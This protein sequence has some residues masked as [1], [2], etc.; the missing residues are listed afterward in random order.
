MLALNAKNEYR[1]SMC[2]HVC[3]RNGPQDI[4]V[5]IVNCHF[6]PADLDVAA[7]SLVCQ[8]VAYVD[9]LE[10]VLLIDCEVRCK[11]FLVTSQ[12]IQKNPIHPVATMTA[13]IAEIVVM[14]IMKAPMDN[15][16]M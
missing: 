6:Q 7:S 8:A 16:P 11:L 4:D 12:R 1:S 15:A 3:K 14:E 5:H 13:M 2:L 9:T 10:L